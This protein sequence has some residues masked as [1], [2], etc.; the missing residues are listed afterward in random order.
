MANLGY[1]RDQRT[2]VANPNSLNVG[3]PSYYCISVIDT[4]DCTLD[5]YAALFQSIF[6]FGFDESYSQAM[7]VKICG[8]IEIGRYSKDVAETKINMARNYANKLHL[9][10][11]CI[12][13][14]VG[15]YAFQKSR[16]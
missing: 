11:E 14:K 5:F 16:N 15:G 6:Q 4:K 3:L 8:T 9:K 13:V 1:I 12:L 2:I 10:F 7:R